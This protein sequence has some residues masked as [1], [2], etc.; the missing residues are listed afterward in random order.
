M[1]LPILIGNAVFLRY[2]CR[3]NG[4]SLYGVADFDWQRRFFTLS[5]PLQWK[6]S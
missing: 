3:C 2:L 6:S 1:A 5:L 4:K